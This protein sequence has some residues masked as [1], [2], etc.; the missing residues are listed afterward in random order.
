MAPAGGRLLEILPLQ[1][2]EVLLFRDQLA[3]PARPVIYDQADRRDPDVKEATELEAVDFETASLPA[4]DDHFDLVVWN[5]ELVTLKNAMPVLREVR[6]IIRPGGLLVLAVPNLAAVHN[7]LLLLAGRQP[8]TLH[9]NDGDH[10]RGF[11]ATALT[12]VLEQDLGFGVEQL[13][14]VG[15]APITSA[16]LPRLLRDLGHTAIWVLR[17][18]AGP[19]RQREPSHDAG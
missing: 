1:G 18:P 5:R 10:V 13:I 17:K 19:V 15:I 14:G 3:Q 9:I 11:A 4:P 2:P 16:F 8:T 6:R 7:R 12:D